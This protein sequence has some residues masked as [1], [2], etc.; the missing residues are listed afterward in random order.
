ML[1][2]HYVLASVTPFIRCALK[3]VLLFLVR[4]LT[5]GL[6]FHFVYFKRSARHAP[7]AHSP[8]ADRSVFQ[9]PQLS[10]ARCCLL[11]CDCWI[12]VIRDRTFTLRSSSSDHRSG[13]F[14]GV[15]LTETVDAYVPKNR[16]PVSQIDSFFEHEGAVTFPASHRKPRCFNVGLGAIVFM[17]HVILLG[18]VL[19]LLIQLDEWVPG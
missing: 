3:C 11:A 17:G 6:A 2:A 19:Q 10:G 12:E 8:V 9:T 7:L 1:V 4:W 18:Q 16:G 15:P 13:F 5:P 14:T